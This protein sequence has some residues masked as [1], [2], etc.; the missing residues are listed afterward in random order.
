M[1]VSSASAADG[2]SVATTRRVLPV[3]PPV[4]VVET[5]A[6]S[7][8]AV[9]DRPAFVLLHGYGCNSYV[10]RHWVPDLAARGR[11][12]EVDLKG[13][14]SAPK[15]DDER[16]SPVDLAGSV[17]EM[18]DELELRR[19]TLVGHS[20]GGGVSLLAAAVLKRESGARLH[21]LVLLAPAAYRQPLPPFVWF[22][23]RPKLASALMDLVGTE[24]IIRWAMRSIVHEPEVVTDDLVEVYS[25]AWKTPEGRRAAL[26]TGR[27]IVPPDLESRTAG[28]RELDVPALV[29]WGDD[30]RVV[31]L[32]VG[33]RL[34]REMPRAEL[35]VL[36]GCGHLIQ[37][38][39]PQASWRVVES[40]LDRTA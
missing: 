22:S 1:P 19:I 16:Y 5:V 39:R 30:D 18:I 28:Y 8:T 34:Q 14:G 36:E 21:R 12:L 25:R 10:W 37:D 38:E 6:A 35:T 11:V 26:A 33:E 40:F 23:H 4:H 20:L 29:L 32:W 13:F 24:R 2:A 17:V 27:K 15:P 9:A 31:P 7:T 3:G